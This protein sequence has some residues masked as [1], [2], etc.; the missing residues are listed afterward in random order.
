MAPG[1][2][3]SPAPSGWRGGSSASSARRG[4]R[5]CSSARARWTRGSFGGFLEGRLAVEPFPAQA[6]DEL[7]VGLEVDVVRQLQMLDEARGLDVVGVVEDELLVL[8]GGGH[9]D[10]LGV[11]QG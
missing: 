9:L 2:R 8:A 6:A 10:L 11:A 5:S 1:S 7:Q 3:G 4:R